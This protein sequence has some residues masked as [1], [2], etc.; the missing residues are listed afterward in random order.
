MNSNYGAENAPLSGMSRK[1]FLTIVGRGGVFAAL[2]SLVALLGIRRR[3][4]QTVWQIDPQK[5]TGCGLC[6]TECVLQPS[7]VKCK[8]DFNMCGYCRLCFGFFR[9]DAIALNEGAENQMC[10]TG[11]IQRRFVEDPYYE[12]T[13][14]DELC[15]GCGKCVIGCNSFGNRSL[16]LQVEQGLCLQCNE[17][18]IARVC[19]VD[20]LV[21]LPV[22]DPYFVKHKLTEKTENG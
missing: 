15:I 8:H 22:D 14:V 6:A 10:P 17:C 16:H 13:I 2:S 1:Q 9:T 3:S 4:R 18:A 5:C 12:Y 7:A 11:A 20:A 21:R 19:P